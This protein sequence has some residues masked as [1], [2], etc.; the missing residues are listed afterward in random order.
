MSEAIPAIK[1]T[2]CYGS[3]GRPLMMTVSP[4][5]HR[6]DEIYEYLFDLTPVLT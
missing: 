4:D 6:V 2:G 5:G 1:T 3:D